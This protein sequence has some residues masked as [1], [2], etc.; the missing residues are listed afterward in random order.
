MSREISFSG[1]FFVYLLIFYSY[2]ASKTPRRISASTRAQIKGH[3]DF[4]ETGPEADVQENENRPIANI[5]NRGRSSCPH[6]PSADDHQKNRGRGSILARE[7]ILGMDPGRE[8]ERN[9]RMISLHVYRRWH[10]NFL[11]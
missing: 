7:S 6:P 3:K 2:E 5:K 11:P 1:I 8:R 4:S 9:Y 10:Q